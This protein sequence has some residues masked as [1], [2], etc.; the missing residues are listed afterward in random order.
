M[1]FSNGNSARTI[2]LLSSYQ[3]SEDFGASNGATS[4]KLHGNSE[5][6]GTASQ[7]GE[8]VT[9]MYERENL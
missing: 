4:Q 8:G 9:S 7:S 3:K 2:R 5:I 1:N 6:F